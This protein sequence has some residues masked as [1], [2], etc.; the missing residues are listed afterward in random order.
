MKNSV[1][2][3][4]IY[5]VSLIFVLQ[6]VMLAG[7]F[8]TFYRK[9]KTDI[10]ALGVSNMKSQAAM[11]ENYLNK[12][13]DVLWFAAESVDYMLKSGSDSE[14][15]FQYLR[16]ATYQM[17]EQFDAN[18][19]GIY[20]CLNGEY[21]DGSGW[22]P[23]EDY[24]PTE[25]SWYKE[26]KEAGGNMILSKPYVDAQTGSIIISYSQLL[27]DGKSVLSL[28]IV[29]NEVQNITEHM[30][31]E[32][33]GYGFIVDEGGLVI[34]HADTNEI[35]KD[36]SEGGE[37]MD[38]LARDQSDDGYGFETKIDGKLCT[39]FTKRIVNKWHVVIV[40]QNTLMYRDLHLQIFASVFSTILVYL[41]I[42]I[43][44]MYSV[45][46]ISG[47]EQRRQESLEQIKQL[48]TNIIRSLAS[49]IDAKDR[50]TSGHSQRVAN[51][52]V[53]I[54]KRMGKSEA[55][56]RVIYYAGLLH[57]VGKIRIPEAVINKPG[58]LTEEEMDAI[59][60]HSVSGYDILIDIYDDERIC[61]CAKYHHE[62]YDGTGYP[63]GLEGENIPEIARIVAV[64][65][66]YDA[67]A[68]DRGYRKA[69][70][71]DVVRKEIVEGKGTQF[72]PEIADIMLDIIDEDPEYRLR[73]KENWI[74]NVLV[75]DDE[76]IIIRDVKHILEKMEDTHV[77][78]AQNE[79]EAVSVLKEMEID[80]ILLDLK[81]PD[82]DGFELFE[83]IREK[84][85][86][87]VILM[88][89]DKSRKT[90]QRISDLCIDDYITK[91][92]NE[93]ITREAV[94][95]LLHR[96]DTRF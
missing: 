4:F 33:V 25:R 24:D 27:S 15:I 71:Q 34:S 31:M 3:Q 18:F 66:S 37:W 70:P 91:P 83:K 30:T 44:C 48:N 51:Y 6:V 50:Y 1:T 26:A 17:Q 61:Q 45:R 94:H 2:K 93:A 63:N 11:V 54:A 49:T 58:R 68:S 16:G 35:G 52:A 23:P 28:D 90:I 42:V 36:Y 22:V 40:S 88:T 21:V 14:Q 95:G 13:G 79:K 85:S 43:F 5:T 74:R 29:L 77:V 38:L 73:Q 9:A 56:Q 59:H 57:D 41:I 8:N 78:G 64:A 72:D 19:T 20:G 7:V 53:M 62:R 69:L 75:I 84:W 96:I 89:G 86:V 39:V 47:A 92:L 55:D 76:E 80:I 10:K 60:V 46:S 81:M 12:G 87:P 65:D 32:G 67:M 82:T